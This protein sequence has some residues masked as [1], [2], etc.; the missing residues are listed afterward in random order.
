MSPTRP[1]LTTSTAVTRMKPRKT[2]R[3]YEVLEDSSGF[4]LMPRNRA[5]SE[6][7]RIDWLIVTIRMPSVVF[8][9][10]I[11]LYRS[12]LPAEDAICGSSSEFS[13]GCPPVGMHTLPIVDARPGRDPPRLI[14]SDPNVSVRCGPLYACV[15]G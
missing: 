1:R 12:V 11:H 13:C 8:D 6:I 9:S 4:S 10:A 14:L 15:S 7:S 5:G 3:K 2:H